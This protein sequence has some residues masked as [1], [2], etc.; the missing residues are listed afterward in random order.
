MYQKQ[1]WR[2]FFFQGK[3]YISEDK[4][5]LWRQSAE[6]FKISPEAKLKLEWVIFYETV[7]ERNATLTAK[8]FG[9]SRKT[10]HKY[11]KRFQ[12]AKGDPRSLEEQSRT[13][14]TA[15]SWEVTR[16]EEYNIIKL[17]KEHIKYGK[18]KLRVLYEQKHGDKI[19]T[20]KVER[21][22]RKH[23]L[24]PDKKRHAQGLKRQARRARNPKVR[25][26]DI[27]TGS[28]SFGHLWHIDCIIL[29]WYGLRRVII[30]AVEQLTR[31]GYAR[32]YNSN[33]SKEAA[34]FLERLM[35]LV[36]GK[37][38]IMHSDNGSEFAGEFE[39]ACHTLN[40]KQVYSRPRTPKDN[41]QVERFNRT[42]Q[43]EW[44]DL[45][46]EGLDSIQKANEEISQWLVEYN[47]KRP[48]QSLDYLTPLEYAQREYF[49]KEK[50][51]PMWSARTYACKNVHLCYISINSWVAW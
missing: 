23:Q 11:K 42:V 33:T 31:I 41:P 12:E 20:W 36:E 6:V 21:V 14:K 5:T 48:H 3:K 13:P 1:P 16:E 38:V 40:I 2:N 25:I 32:I 35:Y 4:Y 50:V 34:D 10:F 27:P 9:I 15:R 18:A 8:H 46:E 19:S 22:I 26:Q 7:G 43:D 17:R 24:F 45:S 28:T 51:L 44:L 49:S 47:S 37:V 30:T 29:N 39:K